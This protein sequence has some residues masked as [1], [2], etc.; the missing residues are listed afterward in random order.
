MAWDYDIASAFKSRD[1]PK[2]IGACIG[3]VISTS[4]PK[5]QIQDSNYIIQ[6][7]QLYIS[8]HLLERQ[9][10][11]KDLHGHFQGSINIDCHP[12][13]GSYSGS[14]TSS[15]QIHLDEVWKAGDLILM[16]PSADGQ[17]FFAVDVIRK[18]G[19]CN[20]SAN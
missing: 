19:G 14:I 16:I 7:D 8:Y 3:K 17:T 4:P 1:N 9:T 18:I 20:V 2:P 11:Y 15:G 13:S 12:C 6:G 10:T 5:I